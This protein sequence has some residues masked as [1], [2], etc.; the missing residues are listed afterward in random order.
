[1]GSRRQKGRDWGGGD[2]FVPDA[3]CSHIYHYG[4]KSPPPRRLSRRW[5][6]GPGARPGIPSERWGKGLGEKGPPCVRPPPSLKPPASPPFLGFVCQQ[7]SGF[8]WEQCGRLHR[9]AEDRLVPSLA[10]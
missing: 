1:M 4:N 7:R 9:G 3:G 8:C 10:H 5:Q 2:P 6:Q